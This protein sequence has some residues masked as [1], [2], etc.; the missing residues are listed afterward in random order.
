MIRIESERTSKSN[1]H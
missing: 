1:T